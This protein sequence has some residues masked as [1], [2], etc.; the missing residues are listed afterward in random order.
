MVFDVRASTKTGAAAVFAFRKRGKVGRSLGRS[1]SE[2]LIAA[3]TSRAARSMSRPIANWSWML[4][5]P[6]E[7]VEVIWSSPAISPSR[8]SRGAATVAA[9]TDGSAPGRVAVT[10]IEGKSTLGTGDRQKCVSHDAD[11][12]QPNGEERG[13]NRASD[14]R[15]GNGCHYWIPSVAP[16]TGGEGNSGPTGGTALSIR[17]LSL[18]SAR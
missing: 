10:L 2:A 8:R 18:S 14:E 17:R 4:V 7:L 5:V 6:R 15:L 11:Q 1:V 12:K 13:A 3:C 16:A 9:I